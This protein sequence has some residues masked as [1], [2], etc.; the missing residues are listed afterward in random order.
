MN[1]VSLIF[2]T[3]LEAL[4]PLTPE[5]YELF[6]LSPQDAYT[7]LTP[8][9]DFGGLAVPLPG[10]RALF[11]YKDPRVTKLIWNIKYKKSVPAVKI[12]G[13]AL[14]KR[15]T[16]QPITTQSSA[17]Q[18][19]LSPAYVLVIP[20]PITRKRRAERGYNQ[21]ELLLD[22]VE[23]LVLTPD[24]PHTSDYEQRLIFEKKLLIR[25]QHAGRHTLK[26]RSDRIESAHGIFA[27]DTA[28]L[29]HVRTHIHKTTNIPLFDIPILVL[30]DVITT[31]STMHEALETLTH[32][33]FTDVRALCLAH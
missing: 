24:D 20:I 12:G 7:R 6:A 32:A 22:E 19:A 33:G 28:I 26:G 2:K 29:E 17:N 23:R 8:A 14:H 27:V 11:A 13:Y 5:E 3:I 9:P 21:C 15:M 18:L 16:V 1:I 30:D 4:Y 10:A 31:G 25:T